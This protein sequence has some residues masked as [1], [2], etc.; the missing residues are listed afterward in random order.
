MGRLLVLGVC[1]ACL[2]WSSPHDVFWAIVAGVTIALSFTR[3]AR[4]IPEL[5]RWW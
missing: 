5:P 4:S 1:L 2:D 3:R